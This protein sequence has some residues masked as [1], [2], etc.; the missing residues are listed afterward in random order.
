MSHLQQVFQGGD[1]EVSHSFD[2]TVQDVDSRPSISQC[3]MRRRRR[4][5]KQLGQGA[6]PVVAN[7]VTG[8][9]GASQR[10]GV[11]DSRVLPRVVMLGI[12]ALE[13]ADVEAGVVGHQ[14]R[15]PTEF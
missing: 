13:E 12:G 7:L 2:E 1:A 4:G 8:E 5:P 11:H 9:H 10:E 6:Q 15:A 14:H 3:A